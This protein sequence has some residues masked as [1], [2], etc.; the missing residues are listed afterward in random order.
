M[1][2]AARCKLEYEDATVGGRM[3]LL[4]A[5]LFRK[6]VEVAVLW[7]HDEIDLGLGG[8]RRAWPPAEVQELIF[9]VEVDVAFGV[10]GSDFAAGELAQAS[11]ERDER[12]R[13]HR[14]WSLWSMVLN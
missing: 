13:C 2:L 9:A 4:G 10:D 12:I 7:E 8:W 5:L 14:R 11:L 3:Q 1:F 6:R